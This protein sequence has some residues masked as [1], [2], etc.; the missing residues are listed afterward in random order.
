VVYSI[1]CLWSAL[2]ITRKSGSSDRICLYLIILE[3]TE[4][5]G[6]NKRIEARQIAEAWRVEYNL[7]RAHSSLGYKTPMEFAH[8]WTDNPVAEPVILSL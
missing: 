1:P 2:Q 4:R 6:N 5:H 8:Q 7:Y 3:S